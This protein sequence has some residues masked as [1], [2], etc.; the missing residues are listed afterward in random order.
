MTQLIEDN[1]TSPPSDT[2]LVAAVRRVLEASPEPLTL[3]K[4]R[5]ALPANFRALSL[6]ALHGTV[7]VSSAPGAAVSRKRHVAR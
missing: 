5:S 2:D 1:A 6:E 3:S 4:I 7:V